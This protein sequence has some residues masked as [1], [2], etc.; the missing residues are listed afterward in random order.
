MYHVL[1]NSPTSYWQ[2]ITDAR[3][4]K[5]GKLLPGGDYLST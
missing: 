3:K 1:E 4:K 2:G 5:Y